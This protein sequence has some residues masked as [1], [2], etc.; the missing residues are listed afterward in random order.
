[1]QLGFGGTTGNLYQRHAYASTT[2]GAWKTILDSNNYTS[3]TVT[4][5]GSGASGT[6]NIN[7][8]G[9][10]AELTP[11]ATNDAASNS[12]VWRRIWMGWTN[13]T[14]GRPAYDDRFAIQTSTG[15]LKA[16]I[17][18][19]S[20]SG[21]A[22][23]ATKLTSSAGSSTQPIYF[24]NGKPVA[25]TGT[26][27][28][29]S[30]SADRI[31]YKSN[32]TEVASGTT[33]SSPTEGLLYTNGLFLTGTYNDSNTPVSYGNIINMA[34]Y[35][36]GQLLCQWQDRD[37]VAG[38]LYYRSHRDTSTGGWSPWITILDSSNYNSYSP[39]LTGTGA[40]GTW[41]INISGLANR[42]TYITD[43]TNAF[44]SGNSSSTLL[45]AKTNNITTWALERNG[46]NEQL[47]AHFYDSAGTW[48]S[49]NILLA[50]NNYTN[51]CATKNHTHTTLPSHYL[52]NTSGP[53]IYT[54]ANHNFM[55]RA[56]SSTGY[57]WLNM[58]SDGHLYVGGYQVL[59]MAGGYLN[60]QL[61]SRSVNGGQRINGTHSASF[62]V[63]AATTAG[64]GSYYQAWYS[65]KTQQGAWSLGALSGDESLYFV[66]GADN[67]Y[68]AGTN[69]TASTHIDSSGKV[70]GAVWN[71]Y[72]EYRNQTEE[73]KPG[74]VAYCDND[75]KLKQTTSRLQKFEG[76]VSDTFGFAIGETE[77]A[78]TPL[79]VSGRALVYTYEDRNTFNSGDCVC[80]GP[81]GR[82]CKMTR[83][84]IAYYPDRIV[85][86]VSEIP[87]YDTWGTGNVDVDGRIWIKIR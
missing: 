36:T 39:T 33:A 56:G 8:S 1:M 63:D 46:T 70:Y 65:G 84:E 61:I 50:S 23:T 41:G 26:I 78:K 62:V 12:S 20:L 68:N 86:I 47:A 35:G 71:D 34:G 77:Q 5:T 66:Y 74:H 31:L 45:I 44:Y 16:P 18:S 79:A 67:D 53:Y 2:F 30:A 10:A 38:H 4:K 69:S 85:G 14:Q 64:A 42:A 9:N 3:Y 15:T 13:N 7:I 6:W 72:A 17:F 49:R 54:D 80:A 76:V 82:V 51:Y 81:N 87:E 75:G 57:A 28:N 60:G 59:T 58:N 24:S 11:I 48:T 37:N 27:S 55:V 32:H 83:E 25:I 22:A 73:L 52:G 43:N 29:N 21:N 40:S 19:G